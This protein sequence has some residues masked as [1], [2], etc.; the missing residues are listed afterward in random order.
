MS[1]RILLNVG[2]LAL[3]LGLALLVWRELTP[4]PNHGRLTRLSADAVDRIVIEP[5]N[6]QMVRLTRDRDSWQIVQPRTLPASRFHV[7]QVLELLTARSAARYPAASM[8][9]AA[10]GLD[11]PRLRVSLGDKSFVFGAA[12]PLTQ[13]RYV[14]LD[15][16]VFLILDSVSPFLLGP[17]WNF[18][19][20]KLLDI[21]HDIVAIE[22]NGEDLLVG[23]AADQLVERWRN[24]SA[25][26]VRPLDE[27]EAQPHGQTV[28]LRLAN[29]ETVQ[30]L[31]LAGGEPRLL[32]PDLGLVYHVDKST[33]SA[34]TG[35]TEEEVY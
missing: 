12:E 33:L 24:V 17:W 18:I 9:L 4:E 8:D 23:D 21:G 34:L 16:E 28:E 31:L 29:G 32:R 20:R 7:E 14:L 35:E 5:A 30:W 22:L 25:R 27:G 15:D 19:D 11:K 26:I 3:L 1:K 6:G 13:R 10:V 2:L